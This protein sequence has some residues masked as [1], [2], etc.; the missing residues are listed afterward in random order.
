MTARRDERFLTY[1]QAISKMETTVFYK[2]QST[3]I[4][5]DGIIFRVESNSMEWAN[6][7]YWLWENGRAGESVRRLNH[8]DII[9]F[10]P[11]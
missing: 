7:H 10:N 8:G 2:P 5:S 9:S 4:T 3:Y 11:K 6:V 1:Q